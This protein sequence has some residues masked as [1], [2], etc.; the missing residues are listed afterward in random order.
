ME[1]TQKE[2][3]GAEASYDSESAVLGHPPKLS[4]QAY[5]EELQSIWTWGFHSL[6]SMQ[7]LENFQNQQIQTVL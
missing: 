6:L 2:G 5:F 7:F 1:I 4:F 3:W